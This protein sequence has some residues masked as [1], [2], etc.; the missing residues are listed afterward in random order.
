MSRRLFDINLRDSETASIP[1]QSAPTGTARTTWQ[2][3]AGDVTGTGFPHGL[4]RSPQDR[5]CPGVLS[6]CCKLTSANGLTS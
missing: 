5:C 6:Y 2:D 4:H 3:S 1:K